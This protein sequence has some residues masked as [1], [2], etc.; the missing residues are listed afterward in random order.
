MATRINQSIKCAEQIPLYLWIGVNEREQTFELNHNDERV[1]AVGSAS[2]ADIQLEQP[3]VS[4]I[5]FYFERIEDDIWIV[6]AYCVSELRVN[7]AKVSTPHQ[8]GQRS[9]VE[10]GSSQIVA[11]ITHLPQANAGAHPGPSGEDRNLKRLS[12]LAQLP[13]ED[14]PTRQPCVPPDEDEP[15]QQPWA[16]TDYDCDACLETSTIAMITPERC[17]GRTLAMAEGSRAAIEESNSL[18]AK[19]VVAPPTYSSGT[20]ELELAKPAELC[21]EV[22]AS[23]LAYCEIVNVAPLHKTLL[24]IAPITPVAKESMRT[25]VSHLCPRSALG[26]ASPCPSQVAT[27]FDGPA[28]SNLDVG[29]KSWLTRLGLLTKRYPVR[30]CLAAISIALAGSAAVVLTTKMLFL[31]SHRPVIG[32]T[33]LS[34]REPLGIAKASVVPVGQTQLPPVVVVSAGPAQVGPAQDFPARSSRSSATAEFRSAAL[35]LVQGHYAESQIAYA[36]L[37]AR[38]PP[39]RTYVAVSQL[40][41]RRLSPLCANSASSSHQSSCPEIKQ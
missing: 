14:E 34:S 19:T 5:H 22:A 21:D 27:L 6:P 29:G 24:G 8:L 36:A 25:N 1:V 35:S 10:F 11:E 20:T 4:P 12:Y 40:L 3:G 16:A 30:V 26:K 7:T 15:T 38:L 23:A 28:V 13:G 9:I 32:T 18:L 31:K 2:S 33:T 37:A 39:D 17:P 41:A